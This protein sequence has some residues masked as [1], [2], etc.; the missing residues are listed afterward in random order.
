MQSGG[1][2]SIS[3]VYTPLHGV[4]DRLVHRAL[5][6]AGFTRVVSVPEQAEPDGAFPTVAFPNPEEKGALDLAYALARK[7][8]AE[9]VVANDPDFANLLPYVNLE[10]DPPRVRPRTIMD[11]AGGYEHSREGRRTWEV[12]FQLTNLTNRTALYNFQSLFVGTRLV[13]PRSAGVRLRWWF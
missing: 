2:R 9:L 5:S 7:Q 1:D 11:I 8:D 13:Q 12:M 10:S 6:E 3:I 4:G